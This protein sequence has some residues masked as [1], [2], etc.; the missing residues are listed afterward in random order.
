MN[1]ASFLHPRLPAA[2]LVL[3]GIALAGCRSVE[4]PTLVCIYGG[5]EHRAD[6]SF[7]ATDG[8]NSC[9]CGPDG[10]VACTDKACLDA[11]PRDSSAP[12]ASA[13]AARPIPDSGG[14][15]T[16][17][18]EGGVCFYGGM[19][20]RPGQSFPADDG[21]NTC[22]C[23]ANGQAGCT[24][25]GCPPRDAAAACDL[26]TKVDYGDVG[27]LR[28]FVERSFLEPGNRYSRT[29]MPVVAGGTAALSCAPP[30][31]RCGTNGAITAAELKAAF[32]HPDVRAALA[33]TTPP[34]YGR[35]LR[36]VDGIVLE[37]KRSDGRGF[38]LGA[39]CNAPLG[40]RNIPTG[41]AQLGRLLRDLDRQ[42]LE[43]PEC[44]AL[45]APR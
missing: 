5:A 9:S 7:P 30:L 17:T 28:I 34:L 22:T 21:C 36:P 43:A 23:L 3:L 25:I 11:G 29:R 8:C 37:F 32:D 20:Y 19:T 16:D 33:E 10:T 40:C 6:T 26:D 4:P 31:P 2:A 1:P 38:L 45:R 41:I 27:G 39:G 14:A 18:A 15:T 42:Q 13:D 35:D 44:Q 24:K 12:P